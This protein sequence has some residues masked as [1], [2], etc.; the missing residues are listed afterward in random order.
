M[1]SSG[2]AGNLSHVPAP[3]A[4]LLSRTNLS[5]EEKLQV[6]LCRRQCWVRATQA[7]SLAA[8]CAYAAVVVYDTLA[9]ARLPRGSRAAA[10]LGA[11]VLFGYLGAIA[12][13]REGAA[14]MAHVLAE[15][16][17]QHRPS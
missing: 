5:H 10:P 8:P 6:A 15:E 11:A 9:L 4:Y 1:S 7:A 2:R 13:G 12:G 3:S 14:V 16:R 17:A